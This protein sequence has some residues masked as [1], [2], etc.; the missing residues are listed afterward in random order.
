MKTLRY[1]FETAKYATLRWMFESRIGLT[2]TFSVAV[3]GGS[4]II[5][6]GIQAIAGVL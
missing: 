4:C 1:N 5:V 2:T 6:A 3:L